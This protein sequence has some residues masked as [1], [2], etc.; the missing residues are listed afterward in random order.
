MIVEVHGAVVVAI[1]EV[2]LGAVVIMIVHHGVVVIM[3]VQEVAQIM[4]KEVLLKTF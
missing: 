1:M 2:H 4:E 3:E